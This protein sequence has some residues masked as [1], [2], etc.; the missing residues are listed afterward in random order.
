MSKDYS[1]IL[2][3]PGENDYTRYMRTDTLL[4]LQR[5]PDEMLHRDELLFQSVHQSTEIWL[6]FAAFELAGAIQVVAD[7]GDLDAAVELLARASLAMVQITGQLEMLRH[8]SPSD[9]QVFRPA[10]GNGSGLES[11]G[12]RSVRNESERLNDAFMTF[13]RNQNVDL[14]SVYRGKRSAP[15][16]RL[17]EAMVELDERVALWR[18]RHYKV[19][20]RTIGHAS[21]GTKGMPV[22]FLAKLLN[23]KFFPELWKVRSDLT[24]L[25]ALE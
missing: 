12:W 22:D 4:S 10:L 1:P 11:P 18:T 3:G 14:L 2:S 25:S 7:A 17:A 9:F 21:V 5:T 15:I 20:V 24:A 23:Q 19:A 8:I 13:V 16:Y 6:K